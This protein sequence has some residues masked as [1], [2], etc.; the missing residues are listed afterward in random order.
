MLQMLN[1]KRLYHW[2]MLRLMMLRLMMVM[3]W[4][5]RSWN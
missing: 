4:G 1:Y 2:M 5:L 3:R